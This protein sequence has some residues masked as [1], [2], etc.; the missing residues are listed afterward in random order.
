MKG[1]PL[2]AGLLSLFIPGVGQLYCGQGNKGIA[3]L[4]AAIILGNLNLILL[5]AFI[6]AKPNPEVIWAYWVPRIGHDVLSFWTIVFWL[7]VVV[8]AYLLAKKR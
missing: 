7:W 1:H 4:I 6:T 3:I 8:D 2:I 5:L